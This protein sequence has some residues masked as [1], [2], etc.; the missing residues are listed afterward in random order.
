ML[1]IQI[2][3]CLFQQATF[4]QGKPKKMGKHEQVS[5][6]R[7]SAGMI[8]GAHTFHTWTIW[9]TKLPAGTCFFFSPAVHKTQ[10]ETMQVPQNSWQ[11]YVHHYAWTYLLHTAIATFFSSYHG[12]GQKQN[13]DV[14]HEKDPATKQ[15]FQLCQV[16]FICSDSDS[17]PT[18]VTH[19][20][21]NTTH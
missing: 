15:L 20:S 17:F 1:R 19:I 6:H 8:N 4:S 18:V 2:Q 3:K 21:W 9:K 13:R 5:L 11:H 12:P 10:K 16:P 14:N 7:D